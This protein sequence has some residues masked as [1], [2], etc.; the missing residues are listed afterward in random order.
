MKVLVVTEI[1]LYRDGVAE[2]LRRL[3][4]VELAATAATGPAAVVAARRTECDVVLVDMA[5]TDSTGTVQALLTARPQ[6]KVVALGV[7]EDGPEV[8][9]VA[10]AGIAGYVSREATIQEVG[11][12]LR[13]A[14]RG[15]ATLSG[16]VAAG[17]LRH[18]ARQAQ[19]RRTLEVPLQLTP[20][21]REVLCLLESGL[22][23]KEI[24]R[25][26]D[27]QLST[28][29]NHVHNVLAKYGAA[30]RADVAVASQ[31]SH[32]QPVAD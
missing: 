31:R 1:R 27:L 25:S 23:N 24:A 8:V 4:D 16:K 12:A 6:L 10:E 28:V 5:L 14:L 18:I 15:E 32:L 11:E 26:L 3:D 29:K 2:A 9:A 13:G 7:P 20:R 19:S 30:G 21:E 17:L 22:T